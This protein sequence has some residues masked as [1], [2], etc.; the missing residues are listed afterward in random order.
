MKNKYE[1]VFVVLGEGG[2]LTISR[3]TR[4][5][6]TY[7]L[8]NHQEFD[9]TDEGLE[10][11]IEDIYSNFEEPFELINKY[12]WHLL[13]VEK[14]HEDFAGY[15]SEKLIEKLE[16]N[17]DRYLRKKRSFTSCIPIGYRINR[18]RWSLGI[19]TT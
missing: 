12:H 15:V 7:F 3:V 9:P 17:G 1:N 11:N 10:I 5:S 4:D 8:Y 14:V 19:S 16:N 18:E 13:F 2:G 6:K